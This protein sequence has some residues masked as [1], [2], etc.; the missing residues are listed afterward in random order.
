MLL[1]KFCGKICCTGFVELV[2]CLSLMLR[3]DTKIV[4]RIKGQIKD[5]QSNLS[6]VSFYVELENENIAKKYI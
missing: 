1:S 3:G 5:M 6:R 4:L 2:Q